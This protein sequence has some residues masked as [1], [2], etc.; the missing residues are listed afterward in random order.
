M[1]T[2]LKISAV[3]LALSGSAS[4]LAQSAVDGSKLPG[5]WDCIVPMPVTA[6]GS[7]TV[8][9]AHA[10]YNANGTAV[11]EDRII[12]TPQ[13][14]QPVEVS[15]VG[16]S[17]WRF[18]KENNQLYETAKKISFNFDKTNPQAALMGVQM[19][20]KYQTVLGKQQASTVVR[21]DDNEWS[22]LMAND[23]FAVICKRGK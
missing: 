3:I 9:H 1:K 19:D 6:S 23:S 20:K 14:G 11:H 16:L 15:L 2:A 8:I 4:A 17:D 12:Q 10:T 22:S 7:T 21:L 5:V 18:S 13:G